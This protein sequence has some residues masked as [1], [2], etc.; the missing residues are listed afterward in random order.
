MKNKLS[1]E[2]ALT[3]LEDIVQNLENGNL[4]LD[5]SIEVFQKG[6]ELCNFCSKK[7]DDAEKKITMLIQTQSGEFEEIPFSNGGE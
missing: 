6:I 1:F 2:E 4:N 5:E 3:Q 7:L